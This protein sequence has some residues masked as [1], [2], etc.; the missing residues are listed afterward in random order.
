MKATNFIEGRYFAE[1]LKIVLNRHEESKGHASAVELR[2]SIYG[3]EREEWDNLAEWML[4]DWDGDFPGPLLSQKNRWIIQ[5][6]RLWRI[7]KSKA[8]RKRAGFNEMLGNI[9]LPM[10]EA[11]LYPDSKPK[12]AKA[13]KHTVGIDSV[14]DEGIISMHILVFLEQALS[15]CLKQSIIF[16]FM[17]RCTRRCL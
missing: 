17:F 6:P 2:L 13:L 1:L 16:P 3:M 4:K 8:N 11:T 14:D 5:I 9:F 12:L 10:F 7:Y 15:Q